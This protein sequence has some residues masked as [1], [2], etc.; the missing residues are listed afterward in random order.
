MLPRA[1][2]AT[3]PLL[4][5]PPPPRPPLEPPL[6]PKPR[7]SS[8]AS[9]PR[10]PSP[11]HPNSQPLFAPIGA[12]VQLSCPV[13]PRPQ[14]PCTNVLPSAVA[15]THRQA[16]MPGGSGGAH[17]SPP[18]AGRRP[19]PP[20][21]QYSSPAPGVSFCNSVLLNF[22]ATPVPAVRLPS[23]PSSS[24]IWLCPVQGSRTANLFEVQNAL[25][26]YFSVRPFRFQIGE[27]QPRVF[28]MAAV[29]ANIARFL[30]NRGRCCFGRVSLLLFPT[31]QSAIAAK[32]VGHHAGGLE[33]DVTPAFPPIQNSGGAPVPFATPH[34]SR[35]PP[36]TGLIPPLQPDR[37]ALQLAHVPSEQ[38]GT[39]LATVPSL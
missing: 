6:Q 16:Q 4:A 29:N 30:V 10:P 22:Y 36:L 38:T 2:R 15:K 21:T 1:T 27:S 3:P 8:R 9:P 18:P 35:P 12:T 37:G 5:L 28:E 7:R 39:I 24:R 25:N 31:V 34:P 20:R 19:T 17:Q 14:P 33:V 23:A 11:P 32:R 26:F 13:G